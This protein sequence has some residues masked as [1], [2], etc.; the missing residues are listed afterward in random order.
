MKLG[1]F[2]SLSFLLLVYET[3]F[4]LVSGQS[5]NEDKNDCTKLYNFLRGDHEIYSSND[6]CAEKGIVCEDGYI[7]NIN[8]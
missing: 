2:I 3:F 4:C 1:S 6:C 7:V 5:C 8:G